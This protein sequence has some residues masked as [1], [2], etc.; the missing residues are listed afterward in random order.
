[1]SPPKNY[2][3]QKTHKDIVQKSGT[4]SPV[5][6]GLKGWGDTGLPM[7]KRP[8]SLP[9]LGAQARKLLNVLQDNPV[10]SKQLDESFEMSQLVEKAASESKGILKLNFVYFYPL[11]QGSSK[12]QLIKFLLPGQNSHIRICLA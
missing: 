10:I 1:M 7:G 9:A 5:S 6:K 3:Q 12:C 11:L 8:A 2:R 4:A